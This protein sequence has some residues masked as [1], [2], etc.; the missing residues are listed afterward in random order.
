MRLQHLEGVQ[1]ALILCPTAGGSGS[2]VPGKPR[3]DGKGHVNISRCRDPHAL[4]SP[5]CSFS[6]PCI[7]RDRTARD[8]RA[9]SSRWADLETEG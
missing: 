7:L 8:L 5:D 2:P 1:V 6:P 9:G 3:G 4:C